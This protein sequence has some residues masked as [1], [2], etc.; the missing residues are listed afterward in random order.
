M[1]VSFTSFPNDDTKDSNA[2][3]T[4]LDSMKGIPY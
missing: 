2:Y 3:L 4:A 1:D